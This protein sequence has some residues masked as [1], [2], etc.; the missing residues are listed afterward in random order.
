MAQFEGQRFGCQKVDEIPEGS[1]VYT[2]TVIAK[3]FVVDV[4]KYVDKE[5]ELPV[6]VEK[7]YEVPT[8]KKK[9]Y[10]IPNVIHRYTRVEI[11]KPVFVDK[12]Y[13]I[14]VLKKKEYE[15]PVLVEKVYEIPKV[16]IIEELKI[17]EVPI[18]VPV[19]LKPIVKEYIVEVAK[20]KYCCQKCGH[21]VE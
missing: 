13:E 8:Y 3:P 5:Y 2:Q 16:T 6:L 10:E 7:Q 11:D 20:L 1:V 4:P 19:I 12:I 14:P 15:V 21:E 17:R 18:D 9:E